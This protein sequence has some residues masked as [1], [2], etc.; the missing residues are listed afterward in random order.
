M[1]KRKGKGKW[2]SLED[3]VEQIMASKKC[4]REE[5]MEVLAFAVQGNKVKAQKREVEPPGRLL[6][7]EEASQRFLAKDDNAFMPLGYFITKCGLS[8]EDAQRELEAGRLVAGCPSSVQFSAMIGESVSADQFTVSAKAIQEWLYHPQTPPHLIE[9]VIDA[10]ERPKPPEH[11]LL[12][13]RVKTP[14]Q[15]Q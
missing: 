11:V 4:T 2:M 10:M 1:N 14:E 7:A 6:S 15:K 5:A 3:A 13:V 12:D 9:K 8:P